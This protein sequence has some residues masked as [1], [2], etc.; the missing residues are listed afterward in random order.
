MASSWGD[1][2]ESLI[3]KANSK[4]LQ[5]RVSPGYKPDCTAGTSLNVGMEAVRRTS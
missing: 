5:C 1:P 4:D 3:E 2:Y